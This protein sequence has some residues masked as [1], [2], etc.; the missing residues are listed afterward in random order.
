MGIGGGGK[1]ACIPGVH[2]S[3]LE[4]KYRALGIYLDDYLQIFGK[5]YH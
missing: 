1:T 5:K 4:T 2:K 3:F